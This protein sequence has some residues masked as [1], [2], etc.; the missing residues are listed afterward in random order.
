MA[1]I[2][3]QFKMI[4]YPI[5]LQVD[6][7]TFCPRNGSSRPH[8]SRL[9]YHAGA[10]LAHP[11]DPTARNVLQS[12]PMESWLTLKQLGELLGMT[13]EGAKK[14]AQSQKWPMKQNAKGHWLV[15][16]PP[17]LDQPG[18]PT[19][20]TPTATI[21][22]PSLTAA[23]EDHL[24]SLK[25]ENQ[26]LRES[27]QLLEQQV[28]KLTNELSDENRKKTEIIGLVEQRLLAET[29]QTT[30]LQQAN[31]PPPTVDQYVNRSLWRRLRRR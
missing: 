1:H 14:R 7:T 11:L 19:T 2:I 9:L 12:P 28:S 13:N 27:N 23:L 3:R 15:L 30:L 25:L 18:L 20:P 5:S 16:C 29:A 4:H 10:C 8:P 21:D 22:Q 17:Q 6:S 24:N 26:R 31:Q